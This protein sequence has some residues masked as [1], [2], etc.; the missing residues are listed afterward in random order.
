MVSSGGS[1]QNHVASSPA[2]NKFRRELAGNGRK[3]TR[4][5]RHRGKMAYLAGH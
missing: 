4:A 2:A 1:G 3:G 5:R